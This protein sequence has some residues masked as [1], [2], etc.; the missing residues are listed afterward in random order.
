MQRGLADARVAQ[1]LAN[2][3]HELFAR[4]L[5]EAEEDL[6]S[7]SKSTAANAADLYNRHIIYTEDLRIWTGVSAALKE[8]ANRAEDAA[9]E[10]T[11]RVASAAA[12]GGGQ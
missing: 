10:A 5:A 2:G 1:G 7:L 6:V 4:R 9:R 12:R 3:L 8:R 11:A